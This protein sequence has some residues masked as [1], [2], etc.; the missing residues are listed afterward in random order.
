MMGFENT[1]LQEFLL[2][3]RSGKASRQ[4]LASLGVGKRWLAVEKT[5]EALVSVKLELYQRKVPRLYLL[6]FMKHRVHQAS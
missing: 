2:V 1:G 5:K 4:L 3:S 6:G